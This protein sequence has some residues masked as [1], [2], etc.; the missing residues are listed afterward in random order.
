MIRYFAGFILLLV[1]SVSPLLS[2]SQAPGCP[3]VN[4]NGVDVN[5]VYTETISCDATSLD[6]VATFLQTGETSS[7]DVSSVS[8]SPPYPFNAGTSIFQ[9]TD[10]IW[11]NAIV[12]LLIFVSLGIRIIR[13]L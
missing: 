10:D 13:L 2:F 7:Y 8:Y 4:V 5:G 6:L 11:S 3:G 9:N 12:C 1:F